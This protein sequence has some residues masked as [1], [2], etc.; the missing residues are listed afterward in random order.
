MEF[1]A[2]VCDDRFEV[3]GGLMTIDDGP[4]LE[5]DIG[6]TAQRFAFVR[7]GSRDA[8]EI[9]AIRKSVKDSFCESTLLLV[10]LPA[11]CE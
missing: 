4:D 10:D 2:C 1:E 7:N 3:L 5:R 9:E 6:L 8:D 11:R